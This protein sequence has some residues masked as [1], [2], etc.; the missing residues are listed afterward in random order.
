[1][2]QLEDGKAAIRGCLVGLAGQ[3]RNPALAGITGGFRAWTV[4][5]ISVVSMP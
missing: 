1:M 2:T 5:M 4:L 3:E